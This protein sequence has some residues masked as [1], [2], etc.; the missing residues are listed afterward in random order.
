MD[1]SEILILLAGISLILG[2]ITMIISGLRLRVAKE[3][4]QIQREATR[5]PVEITVTKAG[6][7]KVKFD[8]D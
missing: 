5:P 7:V 3:N 8:D 2:T 6:T 4:N 1:N